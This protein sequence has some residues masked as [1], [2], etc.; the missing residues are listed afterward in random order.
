MNLYS[1]R[2]F[3]SLVLVIE[4][5]A[6]QSNIVDL[7]VLLLFLLNSKKR[8]CKCFDNEIIYVSLHH[9]KGQIVDLSV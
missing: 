4:F 2:S 9:E 5:I 3:Y 8:F 1:L 7:C 6:V